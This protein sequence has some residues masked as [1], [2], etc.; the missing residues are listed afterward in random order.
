[1]DV[2]ILFL[3][4]HGN[5]NGIVYTDFKEGTTDKYES[6]NKK[7]IYD[8]LAKISFL[9]EALKIFIIEVCD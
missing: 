2:L 4:S 8:K 3:L 6:F 7:D 9:D 1:V 5:E